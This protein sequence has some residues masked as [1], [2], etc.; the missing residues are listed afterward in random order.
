M[1]EFD[2]AFIAD[3]LELLA[4]FCFDIVIA[5]VPGFQLLNEGVHLL[6]C[7]SRAKLFGALENIEQPAAAFDAFCLQ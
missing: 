3:E 2:D 4:D 1:D 5:G 7:E 6:Q